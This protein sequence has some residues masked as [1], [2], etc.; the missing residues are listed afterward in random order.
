[1]EKILTLLI[2]LI[3]TEVRGQ[4][5]NNRH[6]RLT[7]EEFEV[8]LM[9]KD[10]FIP[11][12]VGDTVMIVKYTSERLIKMQ[13][14]ARNISFAKNGTDTTVL[15]NLPKLTE[16]ELQKNSA[17]MK[18][19]ASDYPL[20]LKKQLRKKGVSSVIVDEDKL[21]KNPNN[22]GRY[23]LKTIFISTQKSLEDN[24]WILTIANFFYDSQTGK[25]F[26]VFLPLN[27]DLLEL[28]K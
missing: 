23:W 3:A 4:I 12:D 26:E 21:P 20:R 22:A 5:E 11:P 1:M 25:D 8:L 10:K 28:M 9:H 18:K 14:S 6:D 2:I 13:N 17:S 24:G 27:Y 7:R 19:F 15:S 16:K